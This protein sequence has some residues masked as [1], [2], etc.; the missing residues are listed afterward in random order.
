MRTTNE[1]SAETFAVV[2]STP[3]NQQWVESV[4]TPREGG[5]SGLRLCL[6]LTMLPRL[7]SRVTARVVAERLAERGYR[8]SVRTVERD[9]QKLRTVFP[10]DVDDSH[11]PFE[12]SWAENA[13]PFF[14]S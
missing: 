7:P 1:S 14:R 6:V 8:V 10:L 9:L 13:T 3:S 2:E 12:W 5:D 11:K 4:P